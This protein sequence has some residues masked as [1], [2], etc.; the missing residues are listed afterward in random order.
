MQLSYTV[1]VM[2]ADPHA[3]D[4]LV[5]QRTRLSAAMVFT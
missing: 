1:N 2:A 4:R 5:M 3:A